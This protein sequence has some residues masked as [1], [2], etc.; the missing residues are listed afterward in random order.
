[1]GPELKDQIVWL[2][3]QR[4]YKQIHACIHLAIDIPHNC[5]FDRGGNKR[6]KKKKEEEDKGMAGFHG[7]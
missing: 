6:A 5:T 4:C 3:K 1:M 7:F 2:P